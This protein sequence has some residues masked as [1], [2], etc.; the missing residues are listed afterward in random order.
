M[1]TGMFEVKGRWC[2]AIRAPSESDTVGVS[3]Y[4]RPHPSLSFHFFSPS[5]PCFD[6]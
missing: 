6:S 1:F 2:V 4:K 5:A 3:A